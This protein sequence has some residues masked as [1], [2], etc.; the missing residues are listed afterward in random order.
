VRDAAGAPTPIR[1]PEGGPV[2]VVI[3]LVA[4]VVACFVGG[5][6]AAAAA[7]S[8]V[9]PAVPRP[10]PWPDNVVPFAPLRRRRV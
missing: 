1:V 7:R 9:A 2:P 3:L 8:T 10:G 5:V 6:I 4:P